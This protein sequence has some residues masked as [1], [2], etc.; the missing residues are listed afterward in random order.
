MATLGFGG[1][2]FAADIIRIATNQGELII[3]TDDPN[4]KVEV[5]QN[6]QVVRVI[7]TSTDDR[8]DITAG[9]YSVRPASASTQ[10]DITPT[11]VKLQRG[12]RE[13]V[14]VRKS[15]ENEP[16]KVAQ[17]LAQ[18]TSDKKLILSVLGIEG[19]PV[20]GK[21]FAQ[22]QGYQAGLRLT[23]VLPNSS[24]ERNDLRLNDILVAFGDYKVESIAN[25][26]YALRQIRQ[27]NEHSS[28]FYIFRSNEPLYGRFRL[29]FSDLTLQ[30]KSNQAYNGRTFPEWIELLKT[31]RKTDTICEGLEAMAELS[32]DDAESQDIMLEIMTPLVRLY[33]SHTASGGNALSGPTNPVDK[34]HVTFLKVFSTLN[35]ER[36]VEFSLNEMSEGTKQSRQF[37]FW[38]HM[39]GSAYEHD[40]IRQKQH[41]QTL[42]ENATR[43]ADKLIELVTVDPDVTDER[44]VSSLKLV[45]I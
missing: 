21:M 35:P 27:R 18:D 23:R 29:D 7:D 11:E 26:A 3:E 37:L 30:A 31:E 34:F 2:F 32:R 4:V 17:P 43:Y 24:S 44:T 15:S 25:L 40:R 39:I 28:K 10:F 6:G 12:G 5:L 19:V 8:I 9:E 45:P 22:D 38:L 41:L 1:Y 16:T 36:L 13:V 20:D 42:I 14:R 33:G